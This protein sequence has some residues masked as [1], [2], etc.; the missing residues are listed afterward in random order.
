MKNLDHIKLQAAEA[1]HQAQPVNQQLLAA[2]ML[3]KNSI[4][5]ERNALQACHADPRTG[6]VTDAAGLLAL[7]GYDAVLSS[8][9]AAIAAAERQAYG[10]TLYDCQR[11]VV[12]DIAAAEQAQRPCQYCNGT[13]DVHSITGEWRGVCSCE[14]GK[15]QQAEPVL[16]LAGSLG[17]AADDSAEFAKFTAWTQEDGPISPWDAWKARADISHA[18]QP[19]VA[20]SVPDERAAFEQAWT[21]VTASDDGTPGPIPQRS[22]VDPDRYRSGSAH[23]A[24]KWWQRRAMLAAAQKGGA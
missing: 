2:A 9:N 4:Q 17:V 23:S 6:L 15:T 20:V 18:Q 10:F 24:W 7:L 12:Q 8:L 21:I 14:A 19:A 3:A 5:H 22:L 1:G 16:A 11:Q 13:G